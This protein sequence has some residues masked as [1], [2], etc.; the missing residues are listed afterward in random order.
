MS[1]TLTES[2]LHVFDTKYPMVILPHACMGNESVKAHVHACVAKVIGWSLRC[3]SEGRAPTIGPFGEEL[4]GDRKAFGGQTLA[5]GGVP[6]TSLLDLMKRREKKSI[7]L[8]DHT[9]TLSFVCDAWLNNAIKIGI[10]N[11]ATKT[12]I[13]QHL[14][15]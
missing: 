2:N 7:T 8:K 4:H 13:P 6:R 14:T 15:G 9:N 3:A 1:S 12:C 5:G 11:F 10:L